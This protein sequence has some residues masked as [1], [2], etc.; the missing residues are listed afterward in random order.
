M[1]EK[2]HDSTGPSNAV[3]QF[4][5]SEAVDCLVTKTV[6]DSPSLTAA[7]EEGGFDALMEIILTAGCCHLNGGQVEPIV[8]PDSAN[9]HDVAKAAE[10]LGCIVATDGVQVVVLPRLIPGFTRLGLVIRDTPINDA[11]EQTEA[12]AVHADCASDRLGVCA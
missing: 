5:V 6:S 8:P 3:Y 4:H 2:E 11:Y 7:G 10:V 12:G 9:L 1:D